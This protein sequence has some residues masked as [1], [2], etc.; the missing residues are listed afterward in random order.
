MAQDL[1]TGRPTNQLEAA[2][3]IATHA[4][5][6]RRG[7]FPTLLLLFFA[8]GACGLVYQQLWVR[9]LSL[10]FGVRP[11][12]SI[13]QAASKEAAEREPREKAREHGRYGVHGRWKPLVG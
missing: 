8:T 11:P 4:P 10:V 6:T 3:T 1:A 2:G 12:R 9:L 7:L 5:D 13:D